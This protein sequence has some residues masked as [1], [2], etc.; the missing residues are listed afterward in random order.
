MTRNKKK[1]R[2]EELVALLG[3]IALCAA[4]VGFGWV[5]HGALEAAVC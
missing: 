1:Q 2:R 4:L 5:M 3:V